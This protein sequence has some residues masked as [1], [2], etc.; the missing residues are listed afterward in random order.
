M[1]KSRKLLF[2]FIPF[3]Q[4]IGDIKKIY[5]IECIIGINLVEK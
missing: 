1:K 5:I 2:F 4:K 3:N